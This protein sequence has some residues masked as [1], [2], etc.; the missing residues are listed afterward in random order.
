MSGISTKCGYYEDCCDTTIVSAVWHQIGQL[1]PKSILPVRSIT[2]INSISGIQQRAQGNLSQAPGFT[3]PGIPLLPSP[4]SSPIKK[5]NARPLFMLI[6]G[7]SFRSLQTS[8]HACSLEN[9]TAAVHSRAAL[10]TGSL[11][12]SENN[13]CPA[14]GE[15]VCNM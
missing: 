11:Y 8:I 14:E 4:P 9:D 12:V 6:C 5:A 7:A 3:L 13:D 10:K 1:R 2:I 15:L